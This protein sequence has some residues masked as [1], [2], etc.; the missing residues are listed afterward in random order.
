MI[1]MGHEP[2]SLHK[3]DEQLLSPDEVKR[4]RR[5]DAIYHGSEDDDDP[6]PLGIGVLA[7]NGRLRRNRNR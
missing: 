4:F 1:D 3:L 2:L 6:D 7:W 5:L